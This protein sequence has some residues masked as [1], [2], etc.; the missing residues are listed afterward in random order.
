MSTLDKEG[1]TA[2]L[3][4][5]RSPIWAACPWK[6]AKQSRWVLLLHLLKS[7]WFC[8][9]AMKFSQLQKKIT[10]QWGQQ[11]ITMGSVKN[12]GDTATAE[13]RQCLTAPWM[14][15]A[16]SIIVHA[17]HNSWRCQRLQPAAPSGFCQGSHP[18]W[19]GLRLEPNRT[20]TQAHQGSCPAN[21]TSGTV[22][23]SDDFCSKHPWGGLTCK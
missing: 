17:E 12:T 16:P 19:W 11:D 9:H 2:K 5:N 10:Q 18:A 14:E 20:A 21:T 3:H 1:E 6:R 22:P 15:K 8:N 7:A 4:K 23:P 13:R